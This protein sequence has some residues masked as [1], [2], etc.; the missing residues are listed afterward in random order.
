MG[1]DFMENIHT[2]LPNKDGETGERGEVRQGTSRR[3]RRVGGIVDA[4]GNAVEA[5]D[6]DSLSWSSGS[7]E[8]ILTVTVEACATF[9]FSGSLRGQSRNRVLA[10]EKRAGGVVHCCSNCSHPG[11]QTYK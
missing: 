3:S 2:V 8:R 1:A 4:A 9:G 6:A 7:L 5:N 10:N 11:T